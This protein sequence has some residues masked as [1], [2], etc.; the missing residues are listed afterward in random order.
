MKKTIGFIVILAIMAFALFSLKSSLSEYRITMKDEA[1][2]PQI[3]FKGLSGAVDF[4]RDSDGNYY[5]AFKDHVQYID[6][7]GSAYNL[8]TNKKLSITSLDYNNSV[9]YYASGAF[10]YSYNLKSKKNSEIIKNIPNYGDYNNSLIRVNG[11]YLFVTIGSASNSGVVGLDNSWIG[12]Y[13][14]NHDISPKDI[15]IKGINFGEEETGSFV[16]Y[17]TKN[18]KGQIIT[19]HMI[20]NSSIII[21]NLKT[22]AQ[23]KFAWGIRNIKGIDFNSEGKIIASVGGMEDRGLRPVIGDS[24]YIYQIKKNVW[25]GFPDYAGGDPIS[26]PKFKGTNNNTIPFILDQHP[27]T[28]PPAPI[29]KHSAVDSLVGL[30]FDKEGILGD[31]ECIYFYEKKDNSIYSLNKNNVLKEKINFG[32]DTY[33]SSI[34]FFNKLILLDSKS[35]YLISIEKKQSD[36]IGKGTERFFYYLLAIVVTLIVSIL[37]GLGKKN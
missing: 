6:K 35:G 31:K 14:Q 1:I 34:K 21:Y 15:T 19:G 16:S 37:V 11:D 33:I 27:T 36:V 24:D 26:S 9:L 13:P 2:K 22:G 23:G 3:L 5:V 30:S 8:F 25:Y 4:T 20:G 32:G 12:D 28:N 29:Y 18:I 7:A 17:K 10:I